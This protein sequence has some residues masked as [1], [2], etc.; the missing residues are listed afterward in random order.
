[1]NKGNLA[2][3][4]KALF[5]VGEAFKTVLRCGLPMLPPTTVKQL[6]TALALDKGQFRFIVTTNPTHIVCEFVSREPEEEAT[7]RL[8]EILGGVAVGGST[9][10]N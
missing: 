5:Q 10:V 3:R 1:M 9:A 7:V 4:D 8:F 6:E 2:E